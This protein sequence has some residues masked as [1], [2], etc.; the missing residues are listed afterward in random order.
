MIA[1]QEVRAV[2]ERVPRLSMLLMNIFRLGDMGM[3]TVRCLTTLPQAR[4]G[5]WWSGIPPIKSSGTTSWHFHAPEEAIDAAG[6]CATCTAFPK[7]VRQGFGG[8]DDMQVHER[9]G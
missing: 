3:P 6:A 1:R 8:G 7:A 5:F 2:A 9:D 4:N